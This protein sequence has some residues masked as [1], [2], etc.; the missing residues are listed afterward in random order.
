LISHVNAD[1]TPNLPHLVD[2]KPY[3]ETLRIGYWVWELPRLPDDWIVAADFVH[4]IWTPSNFCRRAIEATVGRP[5][6]VIPH[7][8]PSPSSPPAPFRRE[9]LRFATAFD[10]RSFIARKNPEAVIR[11]FRDAF[12]PEEAVEL[13]VKAHGGRRRPQERA[14]LI[15]LIGADPRISVEER[16]MDQEGLDAFRSDMDCFVS[17]H[18]SEGFGLN[19]AEAMAWGR[20]VIV[21]DYGATAEYVDGSVGYP[22]TAEVT[23]VMPEAYPHGAGQTWAEPNHDSAVASFRAVYEDRLDALARGQAARRRII[24]RFS[25]AAV[26][27]MMRSRLDELARTLPKRGEA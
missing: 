19:V 18:R 26:G 5:I 2:L 7:A 17:L 11:A 1:Q 4:E 12:G 23:G 10:F 13:V 3:A 21:T 25:P 15:E 16:V 27:A 24:E 20:P 6:R 22:V 9:A 8:V 14:R